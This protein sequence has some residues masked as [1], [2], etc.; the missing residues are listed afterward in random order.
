M[1]SDVVQSAM[2]ESL[3]PQKLPGM[4]EKNPI[5][6]L[7]MLMKSKDA[8]NITEYFSVLVAMDISLHSMEVA[9]TLPL[10]NSPL[11]FLCHRF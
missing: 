2:M 10:F 4:V 11:F 9:R 5:V 1:T 8:S 6:A 7:E 3:P